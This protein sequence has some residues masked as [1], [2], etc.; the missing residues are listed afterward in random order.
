MRAHGPGGDQVGLGRRPHT[1]VV[2]TQ[3]GDVVVVQGGQG[4][5]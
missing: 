2:G 1:R 5:R 4:G 3:D